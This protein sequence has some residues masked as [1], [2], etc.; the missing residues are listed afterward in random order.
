MMAPRTLCGSANNASWRR[1]KIR[2]D[3][4]SQDTLRRARA[5][6]S[7][8]SSL[9]SAPCPFAFGIHVPALVAQATGRG[10]GCASVIQST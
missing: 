5:R 7:L 4:R 8:S 9:G 3:G 1:K 10:P 2:P 6:L